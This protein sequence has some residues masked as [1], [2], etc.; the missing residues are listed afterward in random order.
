MVTKLV[1]L[2]ARQTQMR[3]TWVPGPINL[4]A[5]PGS[6]SHGPLLPFLLLSPPQLLLQTSPASAPWLNPHPWSLPSTSVLV[7]VLFPVLPYLIHH[8]LIL[9]FELSGDTLCH[10]EK[11]VLLVLGWQTRDLSVFCFSRAFCSN[12]I[13]TRMLL[14]WPGSFSSP[15]LQMGQNT[16]CHTSLTPE[17]P[18]YPASAGVPMPPPLW[19]LPTPTFS[20]AAAALASD[21]HTAIVTLARPVSLMKAPWGQRLTDLVCRS[22]L[23]DILKAF[24]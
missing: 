18:T 12:P 2:G 19:T 8:H 20:W 16:T 1:H 9:C 23:Q 5:T 10:L 3:R 4:T 6:T 11:P 22:S 13:P 14:H 21:C 7:T 17:I 24:L 15:G